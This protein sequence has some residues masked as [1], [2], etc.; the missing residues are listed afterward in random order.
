MIHYLFHSGLLIAAAYVFYYALLRKETFYKLNR[1]YLSAVLIVSAILPLITIPA[2]MSIQD[3]LWINEA[4]TQTLPI[5]QDIAAN[6]IL[7]PQSDVSQTVHDNPTGIISVATTP[8]Y[9][10]LNTTKILWIL[11]LMGVA[12]F[13][14]SFIIQFVMII[15]NRNRLQFIQDDNYRIYELDSDNSPFSFLHWIFINPS[16][17]DFETYSQILDHEKIH[18]RQKHFLDKLLAEIAVMVFWFNPFVWGMRKEIT[19][20]L[21]FLTDNT[22]L[23][24][25]TEK[26]SYQLNLLK[27]SVPQ[28][29]LSLTTNYN[30]SMLKTRII[31]MNTKKSSAR[32]SW[33]YLF[34]LPLFGLSMISLNAVD[35]DGIQQQE[36][37]ETALN[38]TEQLS[39]L[40]LSS[41][42]LKEQNSDKGLSV[43]IK[44]KQIEKQIEKE[45]KKRVEKEIEKNTEKTILKSKKESIKTTLSSEFSSNFKNLDRENTRPGFWQGSVEANE[46]CFFLNN[47][48]KDGGHSWTMNECFQK[49]ELR[50]FKEQG[51]SSFHV[52]RDPGTLEFTGEFEDEYGF[53]KF[54]FSPDAGYES[55]LRQKGISDFDESVLF[56]LFVSNASKNFI[57]EITAG[58]QIL[59]KNDVMSLAIHVG[60]SERLNDLKQI[61]KL[62]GEEANN[63]DLVKMAIH[64]VNADFAQMLKDIS[65][66]SSISASEILKCKIHGVDRSQVEKL[67]KY[68]F[69]GL[70][71][72]EL[73]T[74]NIHNV[75]LE[76]MKR[77]EEM[78]YGKLSMDEMKTLS[79]HGVSASYIKDLQLLGF[80]N[81][82]LSE[83]KKFAIH[84]V[85]KDHIEG[86][87]AIGFDLS[88]SEFIK[89]K[90]HGLT[91]SKVKSIQSY[92]F[93]DIGFDQMMEFSIHGVEKSYIQSIQEEGFT[94]L[95]PK[96][97]VNLKIHGISQRYIQDLKSLQLE[98]LTLSNIKKAKIHGV[99]ARSIRAKMEKGYTMPS[100][101]DYIKLS[102][103]GN[104]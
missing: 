6:E 34:I 80:R 26:Q 29:A 74:M 37:S 58:G 81:L 3:Q 66:Q 64:G 15:L 69:T 61:F 38:N 54:K 12:V 46:V 45:V 70:S 60:N 8:W 98:D 49:S 91:P 95:S 2:W 79:I 77:I 93:P 76:D 43:Q 55:Y 71:L 83:L 92:G 16:L 1:Y 9:A 28:H 67:K 57:E 5:D 72:N 7:I 68:G 10:K 30:Q 84:N 51:K 33:K 90:I 101:R 104:M 102:I 103:L 47:S 59:S 18:V 86:M 35:Q 22:M 4:K 13:L 14:V 23:D 44:E 21:E 73:V 24:K 19:N 89:T 75:N 39:D 48:K 32:S 63:S 100:I 40:A 25:G 97:I 78:G 96:D 87:R 31:M 17:Y 11:Y 65:G 50:N 27:V 42:K 41:A 53:G 52:I 88:P 94:D 62:A 56:Q 36:L 82:E 85:T 20:N 99:S